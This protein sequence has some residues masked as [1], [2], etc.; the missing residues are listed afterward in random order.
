M[1]SNRA[2]A[3]HKEALANFEANEDSYPP[4]LREQLQIQFERLKDRAPG[5]ELVTVPGFLSFPST[6]LFPSVGPLALQEPRSSQ[7]RRKVLDRTKCPE[8]LVLAWQRCKRASISTV[9]RTI[10]ELSLLI[11][12]HHIKRPSCRSGVRS[13]LFRAEN[14][15]AS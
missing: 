7:A 6:C 9:A 12:A 3:I 14:R 8:P 1:Y 13:P 10:L 5:C 15:C 2:D 11:L 4:G